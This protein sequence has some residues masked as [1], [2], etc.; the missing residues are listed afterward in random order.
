MGVETRKKTRTL[1]TF[2]N[3]SDKAF[4]GKAS[5]TLT[6]AQLGCR[7]TVDISVFGVSVTCRL[8][9]GRIA[10]M[11]EVSEQHPTTQIPDEQCSL[12]VTEATT[13]NTQHTLPIIT[14]QLV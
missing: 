11:T 12:T 2:S 3:I 4:I 9:Q 1:N 13:K 14:A 8:P 10:D 5:T 7:N 6:L